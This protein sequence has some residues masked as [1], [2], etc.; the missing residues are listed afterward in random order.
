MFFK[1]I[2]R[3]NPKTDKRENYYSLVESYR[4]ALGEPSHRTLLSLGY[5]ID[6]TL[7][8][9]EISDKLNDLVIGVQN[10]FP[11][12]EKAEKFT[13]ALYTRLVKENKID[14]LKR[15]DKESGD[16]E[17]V[18]LNT[19]HNDDVRE[20]GSEWM[21]LQALHELGIDRFLRTRG[22]DEE[23]VQLA[24]S[25]IVS[26]AVYPASELKT[27]RFI[28]ENTSICELT[29]YP[30][31]D[32][33][34]NKLYKIS[35]KLYQEK[36]LLE[37]FLSQKTNTLFDL[38]DKIILYDL[39]NTYFEGAKRHSSLARFGRSKEKRNDC[40]LIVL[41]LVVNME[42]FIKYSTIFSGN[43]AD[44]K[45]LGEIIDNLR[46]VTGPSEKRVIVVIDAGIATREN[47][48]LLKQKNYDYVCV[49]RS[50]LKEYKEVETAP[51]R[52]KDNRDR[53]IE[54]RE[55]VVENG[56]SEYYLKVD[57]PLKAL[58]ESSMHSHFMQ[59]F[60]DELKKISESIH[61]KGGVKKYD[62]VCERI[63]RL[64]A[65]YGSVNRM[66]SIEIEKDSKDKCTQIQW[67]LNPRSIVEKQ[68][69]HGVYFLKTSLKKA[70]DNTEQEAF[71]WIIYN[72]IRNIESSFRTLK[73]DLDLRPVFHRTDEACKAHLHLG[74]LA[75]W[76]VNTVRYKL[77]K[78]NINSCWKEII[79]IMNTQKVVTTCVENDKKQLIRIRK[80]SEPTEKVKLIYDALKYKY[81]PFI[82]KK[83]VVNKNE[84]R[85][86]EYADLMK[87]MSG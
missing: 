62:K 40:P 42:G 6:P 59:R 32:V 73:T 72:C 46:T 50:N 5:E 7:P 2:N 83:S 80:C 71:I 60:E 28:K 36:E 85:E 55:V 66:Y 47:L 34:K 57:S 53:E 4:N 54:L 87:I 70:D 22:W 13:K 76:L 25:H 65:K 68:E 14:V 78:Q 18:D 41:A 1:T 44:C 82:R 24:L 48:E 49:S 8:F 58:K 3:Y 31:E 64:K 19:L 38:E 43:M 81:A 15:F 51:V 11:L 29:G 12:E 35:K 9:K 86:N 33:S 52:V 67:H 16:W 63:G 20:L 17:R 10:M 27:A 84:F 45:T 74:L 37:L 69:E 30:I 75:Y 77:K 21:S 26:R 61:K 79:R 23:N 56:D 39:T